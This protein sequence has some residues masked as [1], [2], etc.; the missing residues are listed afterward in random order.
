[1]MLV[2]INESSG[3]GR[4]G[5]DMH[6]ANKQTNKQTNIALSI[7]SDAQERGDQKKKRG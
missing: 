4:G 1:M 7:L 3:G 5:G 2:M 6:K